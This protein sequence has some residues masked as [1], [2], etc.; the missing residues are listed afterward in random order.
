M[1]KLIKTIDFYTHNAYT[2]ISRS[3]GTYTEREGA[4]MYKA[5][6]GFILKDN[7]TAGGWNIET[8]QDILTAL[9][10][11]PAFQ[12]VYEGFIWE[13]LDMATQERK[14]YSNI[15]ELADYLAQN[16]I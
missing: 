13:A 8:P 3:S 2:V 16:Y 15:E 5:K 11:Y 4:K 12:T 6:N 14:E 7:S 10:A 9:L 1:S